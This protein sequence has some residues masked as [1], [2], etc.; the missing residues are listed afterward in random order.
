LARNRFTVMLG[1]SH[2]VVEDTIKIGNLTL[3]LTFRKDPY[4][5]TDVHVDHLRFELSCTLLLR[6]VHFR[7]KKATAAPEKTVDVVNPTSSGTRVKTCS[8]NLSA[9]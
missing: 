4:F 6:V 5:A 1:V 3:P 7:L 9:E 2:V 8:L